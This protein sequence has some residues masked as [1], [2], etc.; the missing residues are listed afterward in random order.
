MLTLPLL[1]LRHLI[2][3]VLGQRFNTRQ[4]SWRPLELQAFRFSFANSQTL[5]S[6]KTRKWT[7]KELFFLDR[8][9]HPSLTTLRLKVCA[10]WLVIQSKNFRPDFNHVCFQLFFL[11]SLVEVRLH[12]PLWK[13]QFSPDD[14]AIEVLTLCSQL[15]P[16]CKKEYAVS[17]MF[18]CLT[19]LFHTLI[20]FV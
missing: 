4:L 11:R 5:Q 20:L 10:F 7:W 8:Y 19:N 14:I 18:C 15:E 17:C 3:C 9:V 6:F 16:L 12:E 13:V 2:L 1:P